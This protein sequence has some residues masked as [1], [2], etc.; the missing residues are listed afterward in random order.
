[1]FNARVVFSPFQVAVLEALG[2]EEV[3][4]R[5]KFITELTGLQEL[6]V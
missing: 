3:K 5:G 4:L 1:M 6:G 2:F